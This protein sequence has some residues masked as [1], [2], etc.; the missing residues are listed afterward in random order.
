[1]LGSRCEG[2]P[3]EGRLVLSEAPAPAV[4]RDRDE[5]RY[6]DHAGPRARNLHLNN[7]L[8]LNSVTKHHVRLPQQMKEYVQHHDI[9]LRFLNRRKHERCTKRNINEAEVLEIQLF[10]RD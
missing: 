9:T 6:V 10:V 5:D 1:M 2:V 7:C 4:L 8:P 3:P